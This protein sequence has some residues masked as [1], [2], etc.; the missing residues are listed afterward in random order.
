MKILIFGSIAAG[1]TTIANTIIKQYP[2]FEFVGIDNFRKAFGDFTMKGEEKAKSEFLNAIQKKKN[3]IIEA[4][5]LGKLG[6]DIIDKLA[7]YSDPILIVI[8]YI[9]ENEI[10]KRI[11]NRT[12]DIPFPGKQSKLNDIISSINLGVKSGKVL[13][14]CLKL[15]HETILQIENTNPKTKTFII[16][17]IINYIELE[18][19][20]SI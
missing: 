17:T 2:K 12:W 8:L 13:T 15:P 3:Q 18:T 4:S 5:G 10:T 7:K 11:K 19:N 1:K 9:S 20:E 6:S 16:Q 14:K